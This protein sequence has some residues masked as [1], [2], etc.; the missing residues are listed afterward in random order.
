MRI[1]TLAALA[2]CLLPGVANAASFTPLG[3]L[4]SVP[5]E[6]GDNRSLAFAISAN[7]EV[8]AGRSTS[9][10]P[11]SHGFQWTEAN[12]MTPLAPLPNEWASATYG[13]SADGSAAIG[14]SR[15]FSQ[16]D[17]AVQWVG[18]IPAFLGTL[19][20]GGQSDATASSADGSVV[21]G[22]SYGTTAAT[23]FRWTQAGGMEAL[24][25]I[26]NVVQTA[27]ATGVSADGSVI[28]GGVRYVG[29][30]GVAFRW[31]EATGMVSIG[32][33]SASA[34]TPDGSVIVGS[35][36][37][38]GGYLAFRWTVANGLVL[39][40]Y[41]PGLSPTN[42]DA[43]DISADGNV[44]VG[45]VTAN[46][47]GGLAACVWTEGVG[48]QLL[49]DILI[50]QG[51][52]GLAGWTLNFASGISD[53]GRRIVGW[54]T[55]PNG[56]TEAF[57]ATISP[58]PAAFDDGP[59]PVTAG[60]AQVI[61]VGANDTNFT[62]PVT[63]TVTTLPTKGTIAAIS[64]P[65]PAAGMAV[66][67]TANVGAMGADSFVYEMT[68]STSLTDLATVTIN[69]GPDTDADGYTDSIDNCPVNANADQADTDGDGR[70]NVC[71]NCSVLANTLA[72][73]VPGTLIPKYQLDSDGDGYGN[74]CDADLNN[75]GLVTTADF[76]LLRSV[77]GENAAESPTAAA[78]DINGSGQ[79]T[80]A[81][82]GLLRARLGTAPGPS[83]VHP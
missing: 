57:L 26:E 48:I 23:A 37:S 55:N 79:V 50:Q 35:T 65:G 51:A 70:G 76:G 77:L 4:Y 20:V 68:D 43:T 31:T 45:R 24:T 7:G 42:A 83:G 10:P 19:T 1:S 6:L 61:P 38:A 16:K 34:V 44:I 72:G 52:T 80:T 63:L 74:A 2:L 73:N 49:S 81:D 27:G 66:T 14:T 71:D 69:I 78:A 15:D 56:V 33:Q 11:Q 46:S 39:L 9:T 41:P 59:I 75:S 60:A 5:P 82:F 25:S 54:G 8:V 3:F 28:V 40:P 18:G 62:S 53:D 58:I 29:Q 30:S 13:L 67:Y 17:T 36:A 21:V 64:P 47:P 32:G 12:G 22:V